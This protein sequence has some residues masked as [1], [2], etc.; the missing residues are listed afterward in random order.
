MLPPTAA[1]R[2]CATIGLIVLATVTS[3]AALGDNP[4]TL[5]ERQRD[6]FRDVYTEVERGNW[7][8]VDDLSAVDRQ[9]LEQYALWPD[10]RATWLRAN[11]SS[12]STGEVESFVEQNGTLRTAPEFA[13]NR[14]HVHTF[15]TADTHHPVLASR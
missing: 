13:P 15:C 8:V 6:L 9:A 14:L 1:S 2:F 5:I 7:A 12:V 11:I 4:G 3:P 10:L